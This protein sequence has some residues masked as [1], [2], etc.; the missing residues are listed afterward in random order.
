MGYRA[1]EGADMRTLLIATILLTLAGCKGVEGPFKRRE[2]DK[3][4]PDPL[5]RIEDQQKSGRATYAYPEDNNLMPK[6]Y[7]DRPGPTGR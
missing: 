7:I 3:L 6:A 5:L 2:K 4:P 1:K